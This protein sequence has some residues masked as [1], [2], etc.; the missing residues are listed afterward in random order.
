VVALNLDG[1]SHKSYL[2]SYNSYVTFLR[3]CLD[4]SHVTASPILLLLFIAHLKE[5]GLKAPTISSYVSG[6]R[7]VL[8]MNGFSDPGDSFMVKTALSGLAKSNRSLDVRLPIT[9]PILSKLLG[10]VTAVIGD[11]YDRSLLCAMFSLAFFG[12]LRIG[13]ITTRSSKTQSL[14]SLSDLQID[15]ASPASG[16]ALIF[17]K[18]KHS[19]GDRPVIIQISP[20]T[21]SGLCPVSNMIRYLSVRPMGAGSLFVR[22][23]RSSVTRTYFTFYMR[24]LLQA[25]SLDSTLYKGHSF[26]IGAASWAAQAGYSDQHIRHLGR[27][28]SNAFQKYIRNVSI[29]I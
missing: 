1:N 17:T 19:K 11:H 8:K 2:R 14:L 7:Y 6:L 27:W 28:N 5:K 3:D 26:R 18:Y 24:H 9:V 20:Q 15:L 21:G 22:A 25:C 13:E 12:F 10:S 29:Q 23:D 16:M 4:Q